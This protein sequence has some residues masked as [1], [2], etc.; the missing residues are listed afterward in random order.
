MGDVHQQCQRNDAQPWRV[1]SPSPPPGLGMSVEWGCSWC[2]PRCV[3][4]ECIYPYHGVAGSDYPHSYPQ[5]STVYSQF[6]IRYPVLLVNELYPHPRHR[7]RYLLACSYRYLG[8][9][10]AWSRLLCP[11]PSRACVR[12]HCVRTPRR[13][14]VIVLVVFRSFPRDVPQCSVSCVDVS[15]PLRRCRL[16]SFLTYNMYST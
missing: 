8:A 2:A 15:H 16:W 14:V 1:R 4:I 10:S 11:S 7:R 9:L 5:L 3:N 12:A 6:S 13:V